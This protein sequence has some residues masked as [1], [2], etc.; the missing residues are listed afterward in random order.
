MHQKC[1]GLCIEYNEKINLTSGHT[2]GNEESF[3]NYAVLNVDTY[4]CFS[5]ISL[6][7]RNFL[8]SVAIG[9]V[10]SGLWFQ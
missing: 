10:Y 5:L 7:P 4:A 1:G 2:G 9:R 8:L 6:Q 3:S